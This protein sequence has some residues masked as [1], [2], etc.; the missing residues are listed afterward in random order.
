MKS[1]S[2]LGI[3]LYLGD[4]SIEFNTRLFKVAEHAIENGIN[5]FDCSPSYRNGESEK[6]IGKII[7]RYPNKDL[8]FSTKGGFVPFDFS[9]TEKDEL[10]Y[11][12]ELFD[13]KLVSKD[14]FDSEFFQTFD[15]NYLEFSLKNTL[16]KISR[17]SIDIYYIHNPEYLLRKR[18]RNEFLS[19]MENVFRWLKE[20]IKGGVIKEFGISSWMGFFERDSRY[21]LQI[22]EFLNLSKKVSIR[23][24]FK[25][26]QVP[27][28][29]HQTDLFFFRGQR[30]KVEY[31]SLAFLAS[32]NDLDLITSA[33]L[34]QGK[35]ARFKYLKDVEEIFTN[36]TSPQISLS[37]VLS[38]PYIKS[39]LI[40]TTSLIHLNELLKVYNKKL[41]G[42]DRFNS[43][44]LGKIK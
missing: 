29:F 30:S 3:G 11:I 44:L 17:D 19:I 14:L 28:N 10:D 27:Y 35:L 6:V 7:K 31:R 22:E 32:E 39:S 38:T 41:Y 26:I 4:D 33:S 43:T 40:G 37:F 42:N 15:I 12:Q 24:Y 8:V 20:K 1:F 18:S 2:R 16:T 34:D 25:Y 5:F 13:N 36:L 23:K 21:C 9:R